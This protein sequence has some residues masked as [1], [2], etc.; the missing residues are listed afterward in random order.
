MV[1]RQSPANIEKTFLVPSTEKLANDRELVSSAQKSRFGP[2]FTLTQKLCRSCSFAP[3]EYGIVYAALTFTG[4][5][6]SSCQSLPITMSTPTK[7]G[8]VR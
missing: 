3:G 4:N 6:I 7:Y 8:E 2:S 1:R 5:G